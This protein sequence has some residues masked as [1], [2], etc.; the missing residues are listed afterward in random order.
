MG[1]VADKS[2][3]IENDHLHALHSVLDKI[4]SGEME[5]TVERGA[6]E[7]TSDAFLLYL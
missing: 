7:S 6:L 2:S 5:T 1:D 3:R 4:C